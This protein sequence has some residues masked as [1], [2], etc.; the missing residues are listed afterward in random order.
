MAL[1]SKELPP[2]LLKYFIM[3]IPYGIRYILLS[4][5]SIL[6]ALGWLYFDLFRI[7]HLWRSDSENT[8]VMVWIMALMVVLTG[9][10]YKIVQSL[11][12]SSRQKNISKAF[13]ILIVLA[14]WWFYI[15]VVVWGIEA[16]QKSSSL[17]MF[18]SI[19]KSHFVMPV[20]IAF[21][22]PYLF[23]RISVWKETSRFYRRTFKE[24]R[25]GSGRWAGIRTYE[26][27]EVDLSKNDKFKGILTDTIVLGRSLSIYDHTPRFI[28]IKNDPHIISIAASGGGKS[29]TVAW[30][31][32]AMYRG[33]II[34]FDPKGEHSLNTLA[35]RS[36]KAWLLKN[37]IKSKTIKELPNGETYM[38]DP[39]GVNEKYGL[40]SFHY[41]PLCEIDINSKLARGMLSALSDGAVSPGS[42]DD[43]H[44]VEWSRS[45]IEGVTAFVLDRYPKEHHNLPFILDLINGVEVFAD[46]VNINAEVDSLFAGIQK[47]S[48]TADPK[49]FDALLD[50]MMLHGT[51]AGNLPMEVAVKLKQMSDRERG[52][53]LSSVS[54]SLKWIGDPAMRDHLSKQSDF[55]FSEFGVKQEKGINGEAYDF[56]QTCYVV[57][58]DG[59]IK[60]Q[61]RW[62]RT[63]I[64]IGIKSM[65]QNRERLPE[66]PTL[67]MLD[68]LPRLGGKIEVVAEGFGILRSYKIKLWGFIQEIGQLQNDYGKRFE[69]IL[70]NSTIQVFAVNNMKT[71]EWVSQDL[72]EARQRRTERRRGCLGFFFPRTVHETALPLL[73]PNEVMNKFRKSDNIQYV[74]TTEDYPM[75]LER[76]SF[77][78]LKFGGDNKFEEKQF[79]SFPNEGLR[80]HFEEW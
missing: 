2:N 47:P 36:S 55:K 6:M 73:T 27:R 15:G 23:Y 34:V 76:V 35:R 39:F 59:M 50:D 11:K 30:N 20:L 48:Q 71:A 31:N 56:I 63:I 67:V 51:A 29:V 9:I 37:G 77:K 14:Y 41:N 61:M 18:W 65:Q 7:D 10:F 33:S 49:R 66:I 4:V 17:A 60:S 74:R 22:P 57:L 40:P 13:Y 42:A 1:F 44:W 32:L 72:G 64:S 16:F 24:N 79:H 75:L 19:V 43:E 69:S 54:R 58:P 8:S 45:V 21:A 80:G 70:A 68:E 38:L 25:G 62:V 53:I 46:P 12:Y 52:S 78:P 26:K 28:G 5:F 3:Q